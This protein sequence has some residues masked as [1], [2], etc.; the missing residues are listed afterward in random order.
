MQ[1]N[2]KIPTTNKMLLNYFLKC[3]LW[4]E[5]EADIQVYK[6]NTIINIT[7][8]KNVKNVQN[9]F[10]KI[11]NVSEALCNRKSKLPLKKGNGRKKVWPYSVRFIC[12]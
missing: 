3:I 7:N 9:S 12:S 4:E 1:Y 11:Q 6:C 10:V 8:K 2:V 5:D